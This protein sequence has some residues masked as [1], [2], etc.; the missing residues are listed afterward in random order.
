MCDFSGF[1]WLLLWWLLPFLL[2]LLLGWLLWGKYKQLLEEKEMAY[3]NLELEIGN[4]KA[5]LEECRRKRGQ[6][7]N[8]I[9]SLRAEISELRAAGGSGDVALTAVP[10]SPPKSTKKT[11]AASTGDSSIYLALKSDQLQV[12]EGI[13]PK[14]E[15][16][17]KSQGISTWSDLAAKTP[18]EL[19][20]MLDSYGAKYKI[21]DPATW[22]EQAGLASAGNWDQLI[23]RQKQ[24]SAG[25][26]E[27]SSATDSKVEKM[28][29]KMGVLKRYKKD[30][31]KAI[32][33]IGPKIAS[34]LQDAGIN[35][36]AKLSVT[37][38]A[39]LQKILSD[40]GSR[41]QLADPGTWPRQAEYAANGQ[42]KELEE[43]Q[44]F[45]NGGREA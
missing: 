20:T 24:L 44:D 36:W 23:A 28:L 45:L 29:I 26:M 18:G 41:Y 27:V 3:G 4:V 34:L 40:A 6:A 17:L 7:D 43:Y 13:G 38:V 39:D 12:V 19:R 42:W 9:L 21:I 2:G 8:D 11:T 10:A 1:P 37:P 5:E 16:V 15:E 32:E 30:D 25:T 31:L 33:G 22:A 35:T 14:M